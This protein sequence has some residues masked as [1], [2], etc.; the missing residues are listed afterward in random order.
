MN[1]ESSGGFAVAHVPMPVQVQ[2][3]LVTVDD[4][5]AVF[6]EIDDS[7]GIRKDV[8]GQ[9]RVASQDLCRQDL[10]VFIRAASRKS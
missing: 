4:E 10:P 1:T 9:V 5:P 3:R 7:V 8:E 2:I 6:I